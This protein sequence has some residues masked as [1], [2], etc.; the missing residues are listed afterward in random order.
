MLNTQKDVDFERSSNFSNLQQFLILS[1]K[2]K[3]HF[4]ARNI[5]FSFVSRRFSFSR[6]NSDCEIGFFED[7]RIFDKVLKTRKKLRKHLF[8]C[9]A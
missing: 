7:Y 1:L 5:C 2:A 8:F 9:F 6:C 3:G 4:E